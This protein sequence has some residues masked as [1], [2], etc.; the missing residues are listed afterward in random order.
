MVNP[1]P[2]TGLTMRVTAMSYKE[3]GKTARIP[4]LIELG[5]KDLNFREGGGT[6]NEDLHVVVAAF[7]K[8]GKIVPGTGEKE[9]VRLRFRPETH[10]RAV[11][12]GLRLLQRLSLP[13]G[14][15]SLRVTAQDDVGRKQGSVHFDLEVPDLTTSPVALSSVALASSGD[16]SV[17]VGNDLFNGGLPQFPTTLR[18]FAAGDELSIYVEVYDTQPVPLHHL[19]VMATVRA[20]DGRVVFNDTQARSSEDLHGTAGGFGYTAEIPL[21]GWAPG[22]YVLTIQAES[23][24]GNAKP[25]SRDI[26]F[27]V[28]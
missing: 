9:T 17:T 28:R 16:S 10:T 8:A 5:G 26:P 18:E 2:L 20:N 21:K 23:R 25:I 13:P 7:N 1:L 19:D 24:L 3:S 27:R 14:Q 6:F 12:D 15:Y 22:F 11:K 4:L